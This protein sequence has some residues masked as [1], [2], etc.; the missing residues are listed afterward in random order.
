MP[1]LALLFDMPVARRTAI[2]KAAPKSKGPGKRIKPERYMQT[3]GLCKNTCWSLRTGV[4]GYCCSMDAV[5]MTTGTYE[6]VN[7]EIL[8]PDTVT[9][10]I[11]EEALG[12]GGG[13]AGRAGPGVNP[14]PRAS[15]AG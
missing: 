4:C 1:L 15:C 10:G 12:G 8:D 7:D 6:Y 3:C 5:E 2:V 14:P 13:W 9:P 11:L